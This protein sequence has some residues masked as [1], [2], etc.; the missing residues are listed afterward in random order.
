M[1]VDE[2]RWEEA[3]VLLRLHPDLK[4]TVA[5]PRARHLLATGCHEEAYTLYK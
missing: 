1:A 2:Q 4:E 3:L 5:A